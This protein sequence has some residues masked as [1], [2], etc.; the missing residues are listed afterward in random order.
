VL[1]D[2]ASLSELQEDNFVLTQRC[3]TTNHEDYMTILMEDEGKASSIAQVT[4]RTR[5]KF[6]EILQL[7]DSAKLDTIGAASKTDLVD[8]FDR[9]QLWAGNIGAAIDGQKKISLEWRLR[10]ALEIKEQIIELQYDLVE[11]L[12]DCRY[13][14]YVR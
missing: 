6:V 2:L 1:P 4:R 5:Q 14:L 9:F 11:G 8:T 13:P 7:L 3:S 12:D 10:D